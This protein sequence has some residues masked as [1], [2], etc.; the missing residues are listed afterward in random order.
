MRMAA[1]STGGV[2]HA[3]AERQAEHVEHASHL[4]AVALETEE[5]LVLVEVPRVEERRPPLRIRRTARRQ[6]KT[7]SR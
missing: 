7:G 1:L 5:W 4:L 3:R 6:K 2:E